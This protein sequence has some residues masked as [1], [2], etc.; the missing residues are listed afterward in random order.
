MIVDK[1]KKDPFWKNANT[2]LKEQF[3]NEEL[4]SFN[5]HFK[6]TSQHVVLAQF[7]TGFFITF[8]IRL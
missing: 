4:I 6:L 2:F 7:F 1:N 5:E 3:V 8:L